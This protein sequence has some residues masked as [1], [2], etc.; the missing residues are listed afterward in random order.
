MVGD[1]EMIN[2][3]DRRGEYWTLSY[4]AK[5]SEDGKKLIITEYSVSSPKMRMT[6]QDEFGLWLTDE[7]TNNDTA[8]F[9]YF[10]KEPLTFDINETLLKMIIE[11]PI[12]LFVYQALKGRKELSE[13]FVEDLAKKVWDYGENTDQRMELL[14]MYFAKKLSV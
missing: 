11:H 10:D 1:E 8:S 7:E 6:Q 5:V 13:E 4:T 2:V 9:T 3:F 14:I 12:H